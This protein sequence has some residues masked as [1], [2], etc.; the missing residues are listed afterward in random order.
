[1]KMLNDTGQVDRYLW[2][3]TCHWYPG[4]EWLANHHSLNLMVQIILYHCF[5]WYC[6]CFDICKLN[7][8]F[9]LFPSSP[10]PPHFPPFFL[11]TLLLYS[12]CGH[13]WL[14]SSV[15]CWWRCFFLLSAAGLCSLFVCLFVFSSVIWTITDV[16][17]MVLKLLC[18]MSAKQ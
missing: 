11:N 14:R 18:Q 6:Y 7:A 15:L 12:F 16:V 2:C 9:F 3:S 5:H 10:S 17:L 8:F 4:R 1:M 13:I